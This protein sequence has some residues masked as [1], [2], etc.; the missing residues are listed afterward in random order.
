MIRFD[1]DLDS[2]LFYPII[3]IALAIVLYLLA[4]SGGWKRW[5]RRRRGACLQCGY[6][7]RGELDAGCPEC[8]WRREA[9]S[10]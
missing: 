9:A 3:G 5:R 4:R 6:D 1:P 7:L 8:G 2:L 10:S